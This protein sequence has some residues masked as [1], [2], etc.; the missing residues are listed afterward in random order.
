MFDVSY[1]G[2]DMYREGAGYSILAGRDA[3]RALGKMSLSP[4]DVNSS[5]MSDLTPAQLKTLDDWVKKYTDVKKYPV[6]GHLV[7]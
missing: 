4:D 5:E 6:V 2:Y 3:S 1:G 7:S